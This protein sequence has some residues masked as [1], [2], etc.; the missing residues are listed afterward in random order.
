[1][2][3]SMKAMTAAAGAPLAA[4]SL[5]SGLA[6]RADAPEASERPKE[7]RRGDMLYRALGRTGEEV[8]VIGVGGYHIGVQREE[9]E[10]TQIIRSAIDAGVTFMDNSWDYVR[11]VAA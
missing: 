8:S 1:M 7:V 5:F 9:D 11:R 6:A 3:E 4:G 10:S 2:L